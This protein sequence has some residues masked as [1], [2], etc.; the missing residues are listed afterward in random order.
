MIKLTNIQEGKA[1][2]NKRICYW[3]IAAAALLFALLPFSAEAAEPYLVKDINPAAD[4]YPSQGVAVGDVYYFTADDGTHGRELWRS[5]GTEVGTVM[6]KD[7]YVG[8]G[9]SSPSSL[10]NMNGLLYFWANGRE[11]WRSDG[12]AAGTVMVKDIR[13]N[14]GVWSPS[15]LT[16]VNGLLYFAAYDGMHGTELWRSNGTAAGTVMVKDIY[17]GAG[18]S[19]P[20]SLTNVNGQLYFTAYDGTHGLELW[21]SDGTEVGTVMV[22]D[23]Y[24]GTRNSDASSLTNVNGLLYFAAYDG[25]HGWELWR[26]N[27]KAA[28][29]VIVK[30]I[31]VG[32]GD[33]S[34]SFLINMNG[35]LYF[36]AADGTHDYELWR[37]NGTA[38]GTVMVKDINTGAG[39]SYPSSLINVNGLLYFWVDDG[40]QLWRSNGTAAGTVMV[41]DI[42]T[43]AGSNVNGLLYFWA[44]STE[45]WR[46]D[47][48][49]VG[50]FMVKDIA[51]TGSSSPYYLTNVNGLLYFT[52]D[53][54][55]HG[56]ELWAYYSIRQQTVTPSVGTGGSLSPSGPQ[57]IDHGAAASFTV[58]PD[59]DHFIASVTGC[60]GTL[61]GSTYTTAAIMADCTVTAS[62]FPG[63][64]SDGDRIDDAWEEEHFNGLTTADAASDYD[65]DGYSDLQEYL[66]WLADQNDPAGSPYNPKVRN[67]PG[68]TGWRSPTGWLPA[69]KLLLKR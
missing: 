28:G 3:R 29:T 15:S 41:K 30:D 34:P 58:T 61:N 55:T 18:G 47:G 31:R 38:A 11:L 19:S 2:R 1:V 64:D 66:N 21:R 44:N 69:V 59:E 32:I 20:S 57:M 26:S 37:S 8:V 52:A 10:T 22:K 33:S 54:G 53:D 63:T 68:G 65:K 46:S 48:T 49:A 12:T 7:I 17:A 42:N 24:A 67:A 43:G 6:V 60:G 25:M 62:F 9:G 27:G 4:S 40:T 5:D 51:D 35:L 13:A 36:W 50:T 45:L 23:I 39:G 14:G 16:N 56:R